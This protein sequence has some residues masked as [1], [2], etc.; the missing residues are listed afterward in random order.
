[1]TI[2]GDFV[3][4]RIQVIVDLFALGQLDQLHGEAMKRSTLLRLSPKTFKLSL[5]TVGGSKG[6]G[7]YRL[8][9]VR[10]SDVIA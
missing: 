4:V 10:R 6:V 8:F 5:A 9:L 7:R 3:K 2:I 1:M